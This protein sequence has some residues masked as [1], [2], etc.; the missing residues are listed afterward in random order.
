VV[1]TRPSTTVRR[2]PGNRRLRL[3]L[4]GAAALLLAPVLAACKPT[5]TKDAFY[6]DPVKLT[7]TSPG[8]V[9]RSR[10]STF[11]VDP[12]FNT[13]TPAVKAWQVVYRSNDALGRADAVSGTVLVPKLP[14]VGLG[15]RPVVGFAVGTRGLGDHCAPSYTLAT[16]TDY[17]GAFVAGLLARGFAVVVTDYEGL[18]MPG[19]HTYVVGR[20][21]GRALLDGVRAAQRLAGTG[22]SAKSPVGLMGYSQ[23]GGGSAWAAQL[24]P[25]YAPELSIKGVVAGGVPAD[26]QEVAR[27]E[28]GGPVAAFTLMAAMG[29]DSAYPELDL[30]RYLNAKGRALLTESGQTCLVTANGVETL[31]KTAFRKRSEWTTSDPLATPAWQARLTEN[32]LGATAPKAP[33]YQFHGLADEM[34]PYGQAAT[35]RRTWCD[36]GA[37]VTW[38]PVLGEH[39]T[40]LV[41]EYSN[42]ATWLQARFN[43]LPAIG[44]CLLP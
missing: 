32:R 1:P 34:V 15:S 37:N 29:L 4:V 35:L 13:P 40:T 24:A 33:V 44:N 7:G 30:E 3:G 38:S 5:P 10:T 8:Q 21:E 23:G 41:N 6:R 2:A 43:G 19:D 11:T 31:F 25:T 36:K 18:G 12:A 16:G 28:D 9:I 27:F 39:V 17:E 22:L 20:S 42:A 14:W 26:L